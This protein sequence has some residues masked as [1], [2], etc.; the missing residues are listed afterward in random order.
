MA[1]QSLPDL[2]IVLWFLREGQGFSQTTLAEAAG[3]SAS[4]VNDY[5]A[6][7]KTLARPRVEFLISHMGL[8]P[9]AIDDTLARLQA[10]RALSGHS[11][12]S[13]PESLRRRERIDAIAAEAGQLASEFARSFLSAASIEGE[14]SRERQRAEGAWD[15]LKRRTSEERLALVEEAPA[16]RTWA[17]CE[18]VAAE[19]IDL[20]SQDLA[21]A[22]QLALLAVRIADLLPGTAP[23]RF[24]A[25]GYAYAHLANIERVAGDLKR[26]DRTLTEAK[27]LWDSGAWGDPGHL[28][29]VWIVWI[30]ATL[31]HLQRRFGE[32]SRRIE[33]ALSLD[34]GELRPRLLYSKARILDATG[35]PEESTRLLRE[36]AVL[37]DLSQEP[38]FAL[39]VKIQLLVNLASQ[40]HAAEAALGIP[41]VRKLAVRVGRQAD[42]TRVVWIESRIA[43]ALGHTAE[44]AA[45]FQE[46]RSFFG[47]QGVVYDYAVASLEL[48]VVRLE[49]HRTAEVRAIALE[50]VRVFE[51]QGLPENALAAL[52][53][54][55]EAALRERASV[56]LA[57]RVLRF[58]A[59]AEHDPKRL[60]KAETGAESL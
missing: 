22:K 30:E 28:N 33:E 50:L 27:R 21:E 53:I 4:L 48:A 13:P 45:G 18:R 58:L 23:A 15:R 8:P 37:V 9:V 36:A 6:G 14:R 42:A 35:S 34:N 39:G 17:L 3:I 32:A 51:S 26:A 2:S 47:E 52:R 11:L 59:E 5:E 43:A 19:S 10:N 1:R 20:A 31:R 56:H 25:Q 41:E 16:F 12:S 55:S 54:F 46:V 24:R 7:R 49:E 44:A 57:R 40:G 60:F 29:G 38:R